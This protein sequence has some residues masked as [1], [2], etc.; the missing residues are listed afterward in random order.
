MAIIAFTPSR[1]VQSSA[2]AYFAVLASGF[3]S[4]IFLALIFEQLG[5]PASRLTLAIV[6]FPVAAFALIGAAGFTSDGRMW[7]AC[8][9]ACPPALGAAS[10]LTATLG[11]IGFVALPGAFFFLGFDALPFTSGIMLGLLLHAIL[12]APFAR[13]DGAS[14][15]AGFIGRRFESRVLRLCTAVALTLPCLL[16]LIGEFKVASFL[17]GHALQTDAATVAGVLAAVAA[18]AVGL[19]GMRGAVWGGVAAAVVALLVLLVLPALSGLLTINLPVPQ[20]A[21]GLAKTEMARLELAAGMN[22][23]TAAAIVL[24]LPGAAPQI[25]V[26]PFLQPFVANDPWSF[27]LLTITVALGIA[28][29]PA[30]FARAGTSPS[31]ASSRRMSVWLVCLAGA[32]VMTLPAIA[33][34]TRLALL[35]ALPENL[36]TDVPAWLAQL[37]HLGLADFD[38]EVA[39]VPLSAV[40]FTRDSTNL[41]LPLAL[42]LPRPLVDMTLAAAAAVALAA[43]A[44]EALALAAMWSEDVAFFWAAPGSAERWRVEAGRLLAVL[45]ICL[46]AVLS[47]RT[48]ADP[49][50]LFSWAMALSGS[51]VF[52]LLV[53]SVWWKRINQHGAMAGLLAGSLVALAQ[54]LLSLNGAA[55]QWFGVSGAL[56]TILAAPLG[57][58]AAIGVSLATPAP[59]GAQI[60]LVR[61]LR[62]GSGETIRDR[63]VRLARLKASAPG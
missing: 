45:A 30:L 37:G 61:D 59:K 33:F 29:M 53:M 56:A 52:S 25:L 11:G 39:A 38:H 41:L 5:A 32:V 36:A 18:V 20:I 14:T 44:A 54:I 55:S 62:M 12:I 31:V 40:H 49:L 7:F 63:E 15:L 9:R 24:T 48:K 2:G 4:L 51:A 34:L 50:T 58:A 8:D 57:V 3:V 17:L 21:Y 35:H 42:G 27:T 16:L 43:I 10:S 22:T 23:H 28:S 60:E 26:K 6:T 13:K 19:G 47:L 1:P 46:G